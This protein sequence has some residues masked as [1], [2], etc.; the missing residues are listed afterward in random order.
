M[1]RKIETTP[2]ELMKVLGGAMLEQMHD[3][4]P[5]TGEAL[6]TLITL[7]GLKAIR[8]LTGVLEINQEAMD[9]YETDPA[10]IEQYLQDQE[11]LREKLRGECLS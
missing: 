10:D 5:E 1:E 3:E 4:D 2:S 9:R 11:R 7:V 8:H 6:L